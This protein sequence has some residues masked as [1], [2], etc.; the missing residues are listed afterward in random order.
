MPSPYFGNLRVGTDGWGLREP[1]ADC[2][3]ASVEDVP[4]VASCLKNAIAHLLIVRVG[5]RV[6]DACE[7]ANAVVN[8]AAAGAPTVVEGLREAMALLHHAECIAPWAAAEDARTLVDVARRLHCG[9]CLRDGLAMT[10]AVRAALKR[11]DAAAGT[12]RA[13]LWWALRAGRWHG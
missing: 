4:R 8:H 7:A 12:L 11:G 3:C 13:T 2:W 5:F 10:H 1:S 9:G 6:G